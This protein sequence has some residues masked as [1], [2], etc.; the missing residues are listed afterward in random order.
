MNDRK[1][2]VY[3]SPETESR[4]TLEKGSFAA[5]GMTHPFSDASL[6]AGREGAVPKRWGG[7]EE[8]HRNK[9]W[10]QLRGPR[11][12]H[13]DFLLGPPILENEFCSR[14]QHLGFEDHAAIGADGVGG[15]FDGLVSGLTGE[16]RNP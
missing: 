13:L 11:D 14:F 8:L 12:V 1:V 15:A 10:I 16:L 5:F 9:R 3:R 2:G 7:R 4:P 6:H